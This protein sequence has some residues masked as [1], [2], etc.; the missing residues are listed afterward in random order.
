MHKAREKLLQ[1]YK[2]LG[3]D[4][5]YC[6]SKFPSLLQQPL[7][8]VSSGIRLTISGFV[9]LV[10]AMRDHGA[11]MVAGQLGFL[12]FLPLRGKYFLKR[13]G[14]NDSRNILNEKGFLLR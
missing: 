10:R 5:N 8:S 2:R 14:V 9:L 12:I 6:F 13:G 11:L 7:C 3:N 4:L 1:E